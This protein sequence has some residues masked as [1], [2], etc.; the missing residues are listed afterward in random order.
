MRLAC[1]R[2]MDDIRR[3][4]SDPRCPWYWDATAAASIA[5]YAER[6]T[7]VQDFV[8]QKRIPFRMLDWQRFFLGSVFG[9]KMRPGVRDTLNRL[10]DT[11]RFR[12]AVILS[13]RGSGKSPLGIVVAQFLMIES[14]M[15]AGICLAAVDQQAWR[16]FTLMREMMG[17][18]LDPDGFI[19]QAFH[20]TGA[21]TAL[22][23]VMRFSKDAAER[24]PDLKGYRGEFR[25]TSE[26]ARAEKR[27]GGLPSFVMV[28]EYQAHTSSA[29]LNAFKTGFKA[30]KQPLMLFC[31]NAPPARLGPAWEMLEKNR[32]LD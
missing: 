11:R 1:Q 6:Y 21:Q 22:G 12:S 31:M 17:A 26:L 15:F 28:E 13:G 14:P 2:H 3:A 16:P 10:P 4:E 24:F 18:E 27:V 20:I 7:N 8:S 23:G 25:S 30:Q 19:D 32:A 29:T 9:W 5:E